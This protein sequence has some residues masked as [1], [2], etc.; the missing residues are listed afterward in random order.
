MTRQQRSTRSRI[1]FD[2][3]RLEIEYVATRRVWAR[4][5]QLKKHGAAQIRKLADGIDRHGFLVPL[6]VDE[7]LGLISGHARLAAAEL[8]NLESVPVVRVDHLSDEQ[9]RIVRIFDNKIAEDSEWDEEALVLEFNEL[10]LIEPELDLSDSGFEVGEID[11]MAGRARTAALSD[12]DRIPEP[13]QKMQSITRPGDLWLCGRHRLL[14]GD[15]TDPATIAE[16]TG[17]TKIRQLLTDPP[18]NLPTKA[19]SSTGRFSDFEMAAGEMSSSDFA[20]FLARFL[21]AAAP[22]LVDG[23]LI[24]AFMDH[25]HIG[26]L[27][28]AAAKVDL[29]YVNLL[30]W[31]KGQAGQ[32]SHYR[33][34]HELVGLF[35]HGDGAIRNNIQLGSFGRNRSNVLSYPGVRGKAGG[36]AR[37]LAMHPSVK[38]IAMIADLILDATAPGE[39]V[40][41]SFG[42][43]GT[44]LIAAE[45]I[46]RVACLCELSPGYVD[47]TLERYDALGGEPASLAA[48]G[49]TFAEVAA[50][51]L[52]GGE[53]L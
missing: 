30:V 10:Q 39:A 1:N 17:D 3:I 41:D 9:L 18:Y 2:A 13:A 48:T 11:A 6:I 43:S 31:V 42:G 20:S 14:C 34:G 19:F 27:L 45:K 5:R 15:S 53:A 8:L 12:L 37:A 52:A 32:G 4:H 7:E 22:T 23:A 28:A 35:R 24:Y 16:L 44:T 38:N 46:D 26:E 21:A 33:S 51:R 49:Q 36:G 40:L 29:S 25:R 47:V 50:E